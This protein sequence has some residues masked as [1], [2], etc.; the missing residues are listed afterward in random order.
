LATT[1][2]G[3]SAVVPDLNAQYTEVRG[4]LI[5][6]PKNEL[7]PIDASGSGQPCSTFGVHPSLPTVQQ[8][9]VDGDASFLANV[10]VMVRRKKM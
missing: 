4:E 7:L 8:L 10:G 6:L 5:A 2:L 9:Y 1:S 3:N